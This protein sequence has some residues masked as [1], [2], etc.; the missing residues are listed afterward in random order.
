MKA[1]LAAAFI[2]AQTGS[3]LAAAGAAQTTDEACPAEGEMQ[4]LCGIQGAEDIVHLGDSNWLLA[5]G[6]GAEGQDG[7]V[8][9]IDGR[10]KTFKAIFPAE[11]AGISP[12]TQMYPNCP[13]AP[14]PETFTAHG[15]SLNRVGPSEDGSYRLLAINHAREAVEVFSVQETASEPD[16]T[17]VGCVI[18]PEGTY[19][20]SVAALPDGGFVATKMFDPS[21]PNAFAEIRAGKIS[22][23][24]Y[25][26]RPGEGF[27]VVPGSAMSGPN[28]IEVSPDGQWIY[29][30]TFGSKELVRLSRDGTAPEHEAIPVTFSVDNLRWTN[31]GRLLA[32][33]TNPPDPGCTGESCGGWTVVSWNPEDMTTTPVLSHTGA[34]AIK[35]VSVAIEAL[36][37]IW[38]GS[39]TDNKVGYIPVAIPVTE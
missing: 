20:N 13:G 32:A 19:T 37:Y 24:V 35:G 5:S 8:H 29:V 21:K 36:G 2:V 12:D 30:A 9:L 23:L 39:F 4:F 15:L 27:S 22:G 25:E 7:A 33:G 10:N 14:D 31:D 18:M 16:I 11:A 38:I 3:W 6:M 17:W 26:W 1:T 28:G 34:S